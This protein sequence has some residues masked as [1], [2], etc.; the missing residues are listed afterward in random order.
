MTDPVMLSVASAVAGKAA[1]AAVDGGKAALATLVRLIR[2]RLT[3]TDNG[4]GA[5]ENAQRQPGYRL[6]TAAWSI[7]SPATS[8][9]T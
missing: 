9:V 7:A 5:L 4:S 8:A 6:K 2:G 3:D 1:E